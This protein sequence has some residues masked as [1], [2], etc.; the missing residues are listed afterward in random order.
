MGAG[1]MAEQSGRW[2]A[3]IVLAAA[4]VALWPEPAARLLTPASDWIVEGHPEQS[5]MLGGLHH[6]GHFLRDSVR[7]NSDTRFWRVWTP[8]SGNLP[9]ALTSPPF[10]APPVLSIP[11]TGSSSGTGGPAAIWLEHIASGQRK[12][13]YFGSTHSS[14][15]DV[16]VAV[17]PQWVGSETR[18]R[19]QST[20]DRNS[21]TGSVFAA[22]WLAWL[23]GSFAGRLAVLC[24]A[25]AIW[26]F[27]LSTGAGVAV[28]AGR[29]DL[30]LPLALVFLAVTALA[31]F[32]LSVTLQIWGILPATA[33]RLAC[34]AAGLAAAA[35]LWMVGRQPRE[36]AWGLLRPYG[37]VWVFATLLIAAVSGA[38][39]TGTGH[40]EPNY[41]FW[42]ATWSTDH[43]L[44]W[45]FAEGIR[46]GDPLA[47]LFGGQWRPT[48]RPPLMAAAYLLIG[49]VVAASQAF[50][51]GNY[52]TGV[53]Y[54]TAG[55][56]LNALWIPV[57]YWIVR[58][59]APDLPQR[60]ALLITC[61]AAT[62][63]YSFFTTSYGWPK[64]F[65]AALSLACFGLVIDEWRRLPGSA[66]RILGVAALAALSLLA[67]AGTAFFLA[68]LALLFLTG[69]TR[70]AW[71]PVLGGCLIA[72]LLLGSWAAF[73]RILLPS[74]DPVTKY[75]LTESFGFDRPEL[76]VGD[77]V[78]ER[79]A[80]MT[81]TGWL[82]LKREM[83]VDAIMPLRSAPA[84]A[85]RATG[86]DA[87][88]MGLL[89]AWDFHVPTYGNAAVW[90]T[91]CTLAALALVRNRP[92]AA[93]STARILILLSLV[94][95][96]TYLLVCL[97][98]P[99]LHHLPTA[100]WFGLAIGGAICLARRSPR[101]LAVLL[102]A[103]LLYFGIVWLIHP[104]MHALTIDISALV[105]AAA[106]VLPV[107]SR[108][109]ETFRR[110]GAR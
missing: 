17:P 99:M 79:Y 46:H 5:V 21:G 93:D 75:A 23:K 54:N 53:L 89:R 12:P 28:R 42:P 2:L 73:K 33:V 85:L 7:L 107:V 92:P 15:N 47:T 69:L 109:L 72:S 60:Q 83:V 59:L 48:D 108:R 86:R 18:L 67:H 26:G 103:Q 55:I 66:A 16:L 9:L 22:S 20:G 104:L 38:A 1:S 41:R 50:N 102:T 43:E 14:F 52:L 51:D 44:P 61:F 32:Y 56:A 35:T 3:G 36:R 106:L 24:T 25:M 105:V 100:A 57:A 82:W 68:P 74:N 11:V 78:R 6:A 71:R 70:Q 65:G 30:A 10:R 37:S 101:L 39:N 63:P 49:D 94:S 96:V 81:L 87:S 90:V 29:E 45:R 84:Q 97:A 8:S 77:L 13:V 31:V 76:S 110:P 27:L 34:G 80:G 4:A 58:K 64:A 88:R 95:L 40:W 91:A 62:V 98:S 19:L